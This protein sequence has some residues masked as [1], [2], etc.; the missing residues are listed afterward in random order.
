MIKGRLL[1]DMSHDSLCYTVFSEYNGPQE[2]DHI[3]QMNREH[4]KINQRKR[5][6]KH[7][8]SYSIVKAS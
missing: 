3:F 7:Y 8:G 6:E 1:R 2:M 5:K 4:G